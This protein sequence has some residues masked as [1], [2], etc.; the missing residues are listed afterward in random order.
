MDWLLEIEAYWT[1]DAWSSKVDLNHFEGA[2]PKPQ[3]G[4][5]VKAEAFKKI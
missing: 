3:K 1:F 2:G 5:K 4:E